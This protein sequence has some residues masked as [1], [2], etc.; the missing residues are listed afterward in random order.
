MFFLHHRPCCHPSTGTTWPRSA[1]TGLSYLPLGLTSNGRQVLVLVCGLNLRSCKWRK[2]CFLEGKATAGAGIWSSHLRAA[3]VCAWHRNPGCQGSAREMPQVQDSQGCAP[4]ALSLF[5]FCPPQ[6]FMA[7]VV[8]HLAAIGLMSGSWCG[9][10]VRLGTLVIFVHDTADFWL[11][12]TLLSSLF[13][14]FFF[15]FFPVLRFLVVGI[16]ILVSVTF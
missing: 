9:N 5:F 13:F 11:E 2:R 3:S 4:S 14:Y 8:H 10:Y 7:H 6:D 16:L 1:F 15:S 12:V